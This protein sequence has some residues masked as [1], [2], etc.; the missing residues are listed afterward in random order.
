MKGIQSIVFALLI[1]TGSIA[2][3]LSSEEDDNS[4]YE[5]QIAD[6]E[7]Q[8]DEKNS[9]I[10]SL[11]TQISTYDATIDGLEDAISDAADYILSLIHI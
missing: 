11:Q 5:T 6:L 1:I 7:E 10:D 2:G 4:E 9:T 3:C 8:L